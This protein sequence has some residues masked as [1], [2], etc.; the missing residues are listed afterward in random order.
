MKYNTASCRLLTACCLAM[1][2]LLCDWIKTLAWI[3]C[4]CERGHDSMNDYFTESTCSSFSFCFL[5]FRPSRL[6]AA[7]WSLILA[8]SRLLASLSTSIVY[9]SRTLQA[10]RVQFKKNLTFL[11]PRWR[12]LL[13][14]TITAA[15]CFFPCLLSANSIAAARCRSL[16]CNRM[17]A[18]CSLRAWWRRA[19][20]YFAFLWRVMFWSLVYR[21]KCNEWTNWEPQNQQY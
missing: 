8:W 18:I 10:M 13:C 5:L 3:Q 4:K 1:R 17:L 9:Q 21:N 7:H 2:R 15:F 19:N 11:A 12:D 20:S 6:R 14:I 16:H